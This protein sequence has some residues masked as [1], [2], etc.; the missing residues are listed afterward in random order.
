MFFF[1][2]INWPNF[3]RYE[4]TMIP[5][6]IRTLCRSETEFRKDITV[7]SNFFSGLNLNR[8]NYDQNEMT[9]ILLIS[10][11]AWWNHADRIKNDFWE[12]SLN[13]TKIFEN[14]RRNYKTESHLR[15]L[16]FGNI[17]FFSSFNDEFI[18]EY[19][20]LTF[21]YVLWFLFFRYSTTKTPNAYTTRS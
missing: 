7:I 12:K 4:M 19:S 1:E 2:N 13:R 17:S 18:R 11:R 10:N 20:C 3:D 21:E 8:P 9:M 14:L 15:N 16:H 6:I 5:L